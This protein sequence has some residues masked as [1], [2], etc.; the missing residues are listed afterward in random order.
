VPRIR[1]IKPEF[2]E[3]ETIGLLSFG[4]R[5]LFIAS[6]N[7]ADDEGLLRWT[8]E[9]LKASAFV[10]DRS[11]TAEQVA[12]WMEEIE[13]NGLAFNYV[14][15][16]TGQRYAWIINFRK[17][18][19]INRP[20]PGKMP[21][22]S[23]QN[24]RVRVMY[25]ERD[26]WTC[27]IC[28]GLIEREPSLVPMDDWVSVD[29]IIPRSHQGSDYPSNIQAAHLRC[30]KSRK[31]SDLGYSLNGSMNDSVNDSV[32]GVVNGSMNDSLTEGKGG[33]REG[34]EERER[35]VALPKKR[36]QSLPAKWEPK[37]VH[38][39]RAAKDLLDLDREVEK[40]TNHAQAN[41]RKQLD[42][43]AAFTQWLI[44]AVEYQTRNGVK[45][46]QQPTDEPIRRTGLW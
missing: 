35:E 24:Q 14:G 22:P 40:F 43:D 19:R 46:Y 5:L 18:Q 28:G 13:A 25:A 23:L 38:I 20:Q 32:N 27:G 4:A 7:L 37:P 33:G 15:G 1:T 44:Q 41:G 34:E 26:G 29:H 6:W 10:Y 2:W 9:Y 8:P 36:K 12:G 30:N 3:D 11:V 31:D 17:H 39:E 16:K 42:W 21:A 45:G